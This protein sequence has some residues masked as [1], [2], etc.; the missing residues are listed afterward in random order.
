[1]TSTV[2]CQLAEG[3]LASIYPISLHFERPHA[4][5]WKMNSFSS[6]TV[7]SSSILPLFIL[8]SLSMHP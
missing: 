4:Q 1:V 7:Y 5:A 2:T 6:V 3:V 8:D